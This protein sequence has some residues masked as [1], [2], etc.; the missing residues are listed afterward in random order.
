MQEWI[1]EIRFSPAV[2]AKL[3]A[4]HGLNPS[5]VREAVSCGAHDWAV[6]DDDPRYGRRLILG[7]VDADGPI[8]VYLRPIDRRD[9]L[10][11]CL[12]AWRRK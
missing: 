12:T 3:A 11:Q 4:K 2:E 8:E 1:G 6:W 5:R 7:G 9:G 10:W